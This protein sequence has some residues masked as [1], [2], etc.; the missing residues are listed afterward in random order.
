MAHDQRFLPTCL[1]RHRRNRLADRSLRIIAET[2]LF[3]AVRRRH[4]FE[5]VQAQPILKAMAHYAHGIFKVPDVWPLDR[6][7]DN[8]QRRPDAAV[9]IGAKLPARA[10]SYDPVAALGWSESQ[11][12]ETISLDLP[13]CV[14]QRE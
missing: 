13:Q 7:S 2:C 3:I 10:S 12:L 14:D 6:R 11:P 5:K 8:E 4:P 1:L 9:D